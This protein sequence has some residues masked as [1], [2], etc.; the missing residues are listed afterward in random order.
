MPVHDYVCA[1]IGGEQLIGL[2]PPEFVPV[3]HM[4]PSAFERMFEYERKLRVIDRITVP[5]H[6]VN[7]RDGAEFVQNIVTADITGVK[8]DVH[9]LE[10]SMDRGAKQAVRIR[11]EANFD[12]SDTSCC[13]MLV[14]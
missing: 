4:E 14:N 8:D 10:H 11:D 13:V 6:G 5:R 7:W 2:G 1:G 3:T 12:Q 9:S